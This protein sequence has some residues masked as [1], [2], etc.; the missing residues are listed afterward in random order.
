MFTLDFV[1]LKEWLSTMESSSAKQKTDPGGYV[2]IDTLQDQVRKKVL[3]RG[4]E[5]NILVVGQNLSKLS[6]LVIQDSI[7]R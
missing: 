6:G 1:S 7:L 4:F 5:F 2:G 3:R